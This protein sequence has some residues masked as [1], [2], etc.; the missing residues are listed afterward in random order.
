MS[1]IPTAASILVGLAL[2]VAGA[3]KLA[4]RDTWPAQAESFGVPAWT[5]PIVPWCELAVGALL[6]VQIARPTM[7]LVAIGLLAAFTVILAA[8]LRKGEHPPCACFGAWS[9]KPISGGHIV[10]NLVLIALAV[11]ATL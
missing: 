7:A 9:S 8:K 10:R 1:A 3:A 2:V 5:V 11:V 6:I 4:A